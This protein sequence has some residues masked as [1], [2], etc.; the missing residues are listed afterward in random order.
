[1]KRVLAVFAI[2]TVPLLL[3]ATVRQTARFQALRAEAIRLEALQKD[4]IEQ[5]RKLLAAISVLSSRSRVDEA[6]RKSLGLSPVRPEGILRIRIE[7][8]GSGIDG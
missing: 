1:M 3:L 5:N 4:W 6:A 2:L 7:K 8:P